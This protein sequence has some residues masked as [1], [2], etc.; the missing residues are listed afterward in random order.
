MF[1]LYLDASGTPEQQ[2]VN[3]RHYVY[4]G[5]CM[6]EGSWF[7]L[8]RRLQVLEAKYAYPST[9]F[10]LHV[11]QFAITIKEQDSIPHFEE[12][13][14]ADRR[15]KVLEIRHQLIAAETTP[16]DRRKRRDRYKETDPFIHLSRR[17][18]SQMLEDAVDVIAGHE[19]VKLFG[20]AIDKRHP[21]V[22]GKGVDPVCQAFTQVVARFDKYLQMRH[23]WQLQAASRPPI[24]KGLLILD[25]DEST[26]ATLH[27][28]FKGFRR[29]GHALG[30]MRHV[31][32][33]PFFAPSDRVGGLQ[34]ADVCAY[35]VR[36]YLD[37][38]A[39][40]GSHEE[41]QFLKLFQR[42]DRDRYGRL[43]GLR[44]YTPTG[45]CRCR[46]CLERGHGPAE[47]G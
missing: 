35:V 32:D 10:E 27:N 8:D 37:T 40:E 28:T 42:F 46:I 30:E 25:K 23:S 44:H 3:T 15:E 24:N 33:V 11:K 43:H 18:R 20:E 13:S 22:V 2:D 29:H 34:F 19:K 36:R 21:T 4:V 9:A 12:M 17:E 16:D 1:L 39:R 41:R 47:S 26:E 6:H 45:T 5:L 31:I 7:G 14:R 38:G